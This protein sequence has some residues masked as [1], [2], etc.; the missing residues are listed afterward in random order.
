MWNPRTVTAAVALAMT[1]AATAFA[2][3]RSDLDERPGV[4]NERGAREARIALPRTAGGAIDVPKLI[5]ELR[6]AITRGARD[7][8]F[9]D[10]A[11][12]ASDA[13]T[14]RELSARF[15]FEDVRIREEGHRV[16]V[17]F[18]DTDR[19]ELRKR[20]DAE[21]PERARGPERVQKVERAERPE[22]NER[23]EKAERPERGERPDR[24]GRH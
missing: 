12:S 21:G 14:L 9:Q 4:R 3:V 8:R 24:S 23:A 1:A 20:V 15:G 17:D 11:L 16:R 19:D 22:K 2:A 7:I 5:V 10:A 18:R 13:A 6:A